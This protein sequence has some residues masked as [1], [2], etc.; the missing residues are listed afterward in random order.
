MN[1]RQ[2]IHRAEMMDAPDVSVGDMRLALRDLDTIN[3]RLG[4]FRTSLALLRGRLLSAGGPVSLLD[5][6]AGGAGTARFLR[7]WAE[8]NG[9]DLRITLIDIHSAV[10]GVAAELIRDDDGLRL[11]RTDAFHLPFPDRAFDFAH[12][13]LFLHHFRQD[14]IVDLLAEMGRVTSGGV[15]IND[16]RRHAVAY[17]AIRLLSRLFAN[18]PIVHH[19]APLSVQR[20]FRA[21]DLD[22]WRRTETLSGLGYARR[23]PYRWAGWI[24]ADG[25]TPEEAPGRA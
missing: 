24:F 20:G 14:E 22:D 6:G 4:G 15:V 11:V 5:V 16:L 23:W 21:E 17:W 10:C 13:A 12:A 8:R 2:R 19:D 7:S 18:S 25:G 3:A 9:I 1:F